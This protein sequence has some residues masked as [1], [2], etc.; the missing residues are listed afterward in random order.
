M[1]PFQGL[2]E[3]DAE[4]YP[5]RI[6]PLYGRSPFACL[7]RYGRAVGLVST[8]FRVSKFFVRNGLP[9]KSPFVYGFSPLGFLFQNPAKGVVLF[10]EM[11]GREAERG[12]TVPFMRGGFCFVPNRSARFSCVRFETILLRDDRDCAVDRLLTNRPR[13]GK[14]FAWP[15]DARA[16]TRP[17]ERVFRLD[18][19][20]LTERLLLN[21]FPE[22]VFCSEI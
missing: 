16:L 20:A 19:C 15:K 13:C 12:E 14:K 4:T 2:P 9:A 18:A 7:T 21:F 6:G 11:K 8:G 17:P 10:R 3:E 5:P 1:S 22:R